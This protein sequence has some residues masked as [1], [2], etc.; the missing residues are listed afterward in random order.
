M[1]SVLPTVA[2][3]NQIELVSILERCERDRDKV[4]GNY[5]HKWINKRIVMLRTRNRHVHVHVKNKNSPHA[6]CI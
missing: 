4:R 5:I 2:V 6:Y 1:N 3:C